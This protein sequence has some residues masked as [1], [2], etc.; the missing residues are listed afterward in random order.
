M[1]STISHSF[2]GARGVSK[3]CMSSLY[4]VSSSAKQTFCKE[5]ALSKLMSVWPKRSYIVSNGKLLLLGENFHACV[6][7]YF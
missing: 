5:A 1:S 2:L 4:H 7:A 3:T 6:K